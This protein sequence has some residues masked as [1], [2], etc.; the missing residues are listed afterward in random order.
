MKSIDIAS[1]LNS[2]YKQKVEILE[3]KNWQPVELYFSWVC[4]SKHSQRDW[5]P[6][7]DGVQT[8]CS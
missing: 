1:K 5:G 3:M 2:I 6:G 4:F 7:R 8:E